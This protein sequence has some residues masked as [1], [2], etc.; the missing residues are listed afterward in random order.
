MRVHYDHQIFSTQRTGGI[1]QYF[2]GLIEW[3]AKQ[4]EPK[5]SLGFRFYLSE[6]LGAGRDRIRIPRFAGS[7]RLCRFLNEAL[8]PPV[9]A[10][11]VHSTYYDPRYLCAGGN[12]PKVVTVHDMIPELFPAYFAHNP[13]L[14]KRAYVEAAKRIICVS[15]TTKND[16]VTLFGVP[17]AKIDV[18]H[19][20]I[21]LERARS[22]LAPI[23]RPP[24]Y[25]LHIG[26]RAGYK[27][28][29]VV[30]AAMK[31]LWAA[32]CP[33]ALLCIGG[34]A[35]S[36]KERESIGADIGKI[37]H[38]HPNDRQVR[39][40]LK[41]AVALIAPSLYEGF[42]F[43]IIEAFALDCPV[44]LAAASCF[45]EIAGDAAIYFDPRDAQDLANAIGMLVDDDRLAAKLSAAGR[46][47]VT[48]YTFARMAEKTLRT[49]GA[50]L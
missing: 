19:H 39:Y 40:L 17:E 12:T 31:K 37:A 33:V 9:R 49:Y 48:Q 10:D 16:L 15:H 11:V 25:L 43:P 5:I 8:R 6:H 14:A 27:N 45:P 4:G 24:R 46:R 32:G 35:F 38:L 7:G 3:Y 28:F 42:G 29:G 2:A 20:G 26:N 23:A 22:E 18:I 1:S 41:H 47:L 36:P 30:L 34:G 44:V 50:A 13:H 21:D